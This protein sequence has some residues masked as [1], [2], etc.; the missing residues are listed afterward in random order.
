MS[1]RG[2][3]NFGGE[4]N[5]YCHYDNYPEGAAGKII[6]A[7]RLAWALPRYEPD[8]FAAAFVAA[9]KER[10]GG[11]RLMPSGDPLT[12]ANQNCA[13]IEFMYEIREV[14]G[15]WYVKAYH[16]RGFMNL[17]KKLV[18]EGPVSRLNEAELVD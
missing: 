5:V 7:Q 8:E 13:D 15:V 10:S 17:T 4:I 2:L 3:Y 14:S 12:V 18:Y 11:V 6:D 16:V 1:T 9:N